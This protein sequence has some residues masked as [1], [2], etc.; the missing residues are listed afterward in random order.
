MK[1]SAFSSAKWITSMTCV[2][3]LPFALVFPLQFH[4]CHLCSHE[5]PSQGSQW[6][7]CRLSAASFFFLLLP[8]FHTTFFLKP[9]LPITARALHRLFIFSGSSIILC[10][11]LVNHLPLLPTNHWGLNDMMFL[12]T[13]RRLYRYP[14]VCN[15][16]MF[17]HLFCV[18][19]SWQ[20]QPTFQLPLGIWLFLVQIHPPHAELTILSHVGPSFCCIICAHTRP[21]QRS[22]VSFPIIVW[23][24]YMSRSG[25]ATSYGNSIFT[26]SKSWAKTRILFLKVKKIAVIPMVSSELERRNMQCSQQASVKPQHS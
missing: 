11:F 10:Y 22:C 2:Y 20:S 26:V 4:F 8:A 15:L 21:G 1:C 16:I 9:H 17:W 14:S 19:P 12:K 7:L 13:F 5:W 6:F 24:G 25:I 23:L 18:F 3:W